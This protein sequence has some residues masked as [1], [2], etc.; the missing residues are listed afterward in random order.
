M[1]HGRFRYL[2]ALT[3]YYHVSPHLKPKNFPANDTISGLASGLAE[4]H[5]AYGVPRWNDPLL[6]SL[7]LTSLQRIYF[8]CHT[9]QRA[10]RL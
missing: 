3:D 1:K 9:A 5:K 2:H 6:V 7:P 10:Q 8:V 4:A